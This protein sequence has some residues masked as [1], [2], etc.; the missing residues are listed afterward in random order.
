M[1]ADRS[2]RAAARRV[3]HQRGAI[4]CASGQTALPDAP[5]V[6]GI[7]HRTQQH[8]AAFALRQ[9]ADGAFIGRALDEV[10]SQ[11]PGMMRSSTSGGRILMLD[12]SVMPRRRYL[13]REPPRESR[14]LRLGRVDTNDV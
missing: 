3:W 6:S 8:K 10:A 13:P 2:V 1:F 7:K 11:W 5:V 4:A 9:H 12:M 14:R